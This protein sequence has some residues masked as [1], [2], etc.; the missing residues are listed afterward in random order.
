VRY[1]GKSNKPDL[2]L[3]YHINSVGKL[4]CVDHL[5]QWLR[6][7]VGGG[8]RPVLKVLFTVPD[9]MHWKTAERFLIAS[10]RYFGFPLVNMTVGGDGVEFISDELEKRRLA[11][12]KAGMTADVCARKSASMKAMWAKPGARERMVAA[13]KVWANLP[14]QRKRLTAAARLP[15]SPEAKA[16]Q[17][18]GLAAY[19][20]RP[21]IKALYRETMKSRMKNPAYA[22]RVIA[23]S[24]S[25]RAA[26][27]QR[28]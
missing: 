16:N 23:A 19:H 26:R 11:R 5:H 28:N 12:C 7:L 10:A 21:E 15:R 22:K 18:A 20:T 8:F 6:K 4:D 25:A 3:Y 1:V 24:I 27:K 9:D 13:N 2:R 14:E 17:A